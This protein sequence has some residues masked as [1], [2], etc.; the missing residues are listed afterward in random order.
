[1][2]GSALNLPKILIKILIDAF[3]ILE[4]E[5]TFLILDIKSIF[6]TSEVFILGSDIEEYYFILNSASP[7]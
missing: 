5:T 4:I 7:S 2:R 3:L 1:M 6:L